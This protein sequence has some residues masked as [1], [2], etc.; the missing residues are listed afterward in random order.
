MPLPCTE[1]CHKKLSNILRPV[2][3]EI[4]EKF[5][6]KVAGHHYTFFFHLTLSKTGAFSVLRILNFKITTEWVKGN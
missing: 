3:I 2:T 4:L 5:K 1:L 6:T